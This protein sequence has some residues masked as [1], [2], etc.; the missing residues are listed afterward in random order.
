[1]LDPTVLGIFVLLLLWLVEELTKACVKRGK[2][3]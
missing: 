1:M 3:V 2:D